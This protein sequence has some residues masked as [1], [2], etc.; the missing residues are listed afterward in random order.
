MVQNV[1]QLFTFLCIL[2][3]NFRMATI[4]YYLPDSKNEYASVYCRFRN[5]RSCDL[6]IVM[7]NIKV[8]VKKWN[9]SKEKI[10]P[11]EEINYT[12][13]NDK[14]GGFKSYLE[15]LVKNDIEYKINFNQEWLRKEYEGYLNID[16]SKAESNPK[17]YLSDFLQDFVD[18]KIDNHRGKLKKKLSKNTKDQYLTT[19]NKL[20]D[21]EKYTTSKIKFNEINQDFCDSLVDFLEKEQQLTGSTI[22]TYLTKIKAIIDIAEKNDIKIKNVKDYL[23][24]EINKTFDVYLTKE[25]LENLEKLEIEKKYQDNARNWF[26]IECHTGLR[27][28]DLSKLSKADIV[29]KKIGSKNVR[30]VN[31][32]QT[33]TG[34]LIFIPFNKSIENILSKNDGDFPRK[35]SDQKY[36]K[37]IKEVCGEAKIIQ[38]V[39]GSKLVKLEGTE[40]HRKVVN[41]YPKNLLISSHTGRRTFATLNYL[42]GVK[43]YAIM[44]ITGH[45]SLTSFEKYLKMSNDDL[46]EDFMNTRHN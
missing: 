28:S 43:P 11:T 16:L 17:F 26:V 45:K 30:G 7:K 23:R 13:I 29:V 4:T 46:L 27:V 24:V 38:P 22:Q 10:N 1:V 42:N 40:K 41:M 6:R 33:K 9:K 37:Y 39:K 12:Y 8:P 19:L 44:E 34:N 14:L 20:L 21:F 36:N 18:N 3:K 32:V 31:V 2:D 5:G 25:E 35:I 15:K